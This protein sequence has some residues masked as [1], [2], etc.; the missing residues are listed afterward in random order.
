M[1]KTGSVFIIVGRQGTG[2]SPTI[3]ALAERSGM[4]NKIVYDRR[5]E[6]SDEWTRF[7]KLDKFKK[8]WVNFTD[9]FI[10][11][12]EATGFVSGFKELELTDILI[13]IQHN[14]NVLVFVF[15]SLMDT[16]KY[17]QRLANFMYLFP[18]ND[19]EKDVRTS[20]SN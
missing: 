16:P 5:R 6:Y 15:H 17:I 2:K 7:L 3:K 12:E 13:G 14:R 18:T 1:S 4:K 9:S 8:A 20:R 10:V 11:V 19:E